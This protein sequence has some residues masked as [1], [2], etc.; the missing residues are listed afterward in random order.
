[1]KK[2]FF[3]QKGNS[4]TLTLALLT[5]LAATVI[6]A[7]FSGMGVYYLQEQ[8]MNNGD[9]SKNKRVEELQKKINELQNKLGTEEKSDIE[10]A[11]SEEEEVLAEITGSLTYPAGQLPDDLTIYA[12]NMETEEVYTTTEVLSGTGYT[13]GSGYSMEV[14][15]GTYQVYAM[16]VGSEK[17][18]YNQF[19]VCGMSVECTDTTILEV[20]VLA[21]ESTDDI[22][23]GDWWNIEI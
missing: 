3:G 21:G 20:E 13:F 7:I 16:K 4:Q 23:V 2:N 22:I 10:T 19:M 8:K 14:P 9:A 1:M 17:A 15:A 11:S 18:Y 6:A 5:V 12:K